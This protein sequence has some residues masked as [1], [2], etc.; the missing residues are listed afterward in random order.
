M[1]VL[2]YSKVVEVVSL[3][4]FIEAQKV[5]FEMFLQ[6]NVPPKER[7]LRG[8]QKVFKETLSGSKSDK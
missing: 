1:Q 5:G 8:L 3:P 6:A 7:K 2:N 4:D